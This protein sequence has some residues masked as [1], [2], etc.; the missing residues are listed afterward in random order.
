MDATLLTLTRWGWRVTI[1]THKHQGIDTGKLEIKAT[2]AK[3]SIYVVEL[4]QMLNYALLNL[5]LQCEEHD[6]A[7]AR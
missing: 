2:K 7:L 6:R 3:H 1:Y 4:P 5:L